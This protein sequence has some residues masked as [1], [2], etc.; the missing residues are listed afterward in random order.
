VRFFEVAQQQ[1]KVVETARFQEEFDAY[2][3]QSPNIAKR[4]IAFIKFKVEHPDKQWDRK[5]TGFSG[6]D[7]LRGYR[8]THLLMGKV[9]LIYQITQ[10]QLRL[11]ACVEHNY[12][13]GGMKAMIR[14]LDRLD[15][16]SFKATMGSS[17]PTLDSG[18]RKEVVDFLYEIAAD[19]PTSLHAAMEGNPSDLL[20]Y[21]QEFLEVEP[22]VVAA[23]FGGL[24]G[25]QK[26]VH[27]VLANLGLKARR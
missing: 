9:I 11:C 15:N 13:E 19:D 16:Q 24:P 12:V 7:R 23:T 26:E 1:L 2:A 8:H 10:N 25:L 4:L 14:Y 18:Q 22:S 3:R 27:S 6:N 21:L 17:E 5:D 20:E